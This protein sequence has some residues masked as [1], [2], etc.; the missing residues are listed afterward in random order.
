MEEA[1][2]QVEIITPTIMGGADSKELDPNLIRP[3][4]IKSMMR[5]AFRLVAG[6]YV[7]HD[8]KGVK[9][10]YK[11]E[12][13][14]FGNTEGKGRF[15]LI[16]DIPNNLKTEKI[17]LLPHK[18]N[19]S[20]SGILP[21]QTFNLK[22]ITYKYPA[23]F[24]KALLNLAFLLGVGHRRNRLLG[25]MQIEQ[26]ELAEEL[27]K[28]NKFFSDKGYEVIKTDNPLFACFSKRGDGNKNF[29]VCSMHLKD[30]FK[31]ID[32]RKFEIALENLYKNVIHGVERE[33]SLKFILG[34]ANPRQ[35]SFVNFSVLKDNQDYKL[36]ILG[37]YYKNKDFKYNEWKRAIEKVKEL[38]EK[39]F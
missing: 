16:V 10:L 27:K 21:N 6:K 5:Q 8:N 3:T 36:F 26:F 13:E 4:E 22:I 11:L 24:Y 7:E 33:D 20:K 39:N 15:R 30:E 17:R 12:S 14:I 25:S 34:G 29:A 38:T 37:F 31:P 9:E 23:E 19:F 18:S 35:A 32:K 28:I 1:K 2:L